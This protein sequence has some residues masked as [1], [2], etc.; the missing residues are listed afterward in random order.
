MSRWVRKNRRIYDFSKCEYCGT[1]WG[2]GC[3]EIICLACGSIQC[4][5][6]GLGRGICSICLIGFLPG[7][8]RTNKKCGYKH[9][10]N[11]AICK[12]KFIRQVCKEHMI[13]QNLNVHIKERLD[14]REERWELIE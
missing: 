5:S 14:Q 4:E 8:F 9:C 12:A 7:W 10:Q 6:N 11:D 3:K 13:K 1:G 2:N